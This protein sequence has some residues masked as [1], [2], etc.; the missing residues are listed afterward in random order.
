[1]CNCSSCP[2]VVESAI[3][4]VDGVKEV[5]IETK[6]T[7]GDVTVSFDDAKTDINRIQK[8]VSDLGYGVK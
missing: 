2:F 1:M 6:G 5:T 8:A 4:K 7:E 3:K